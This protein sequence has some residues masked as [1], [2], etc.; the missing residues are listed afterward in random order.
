MESARSRAAAG[1]S[2]VCAR[3]ATRRRAGSA[4]RAEGATADG[5]VDYLGF[6]RGFVR[7]AA[8]DAARAA[9]ARR[10]LEAAWRRS[11]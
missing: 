2:A 8:R 5:D 9:G 10:A 11:A 4:G 3:S 6:L 1:S 7:A